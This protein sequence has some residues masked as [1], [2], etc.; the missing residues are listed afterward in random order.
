L[1]AAGFN[2][3]HAAPG[4]PGKIC[5]IEGFIRVEDIDQV[6]GDYVALVPAGFCGANIQETI[7]LAGI[8]PDDL[9]V[10]IAGEGEAEI[11]LADGGRADNDRDWTYHRSL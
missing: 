11:G 7:D 1:F 9:C 8:A 6:V 10:K 3:V 2:G 5:G 4:Q